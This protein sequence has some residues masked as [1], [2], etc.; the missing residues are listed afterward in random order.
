MAAKVLS[1]RSAYF[2]GGSD[3]IGR[4]NLPDGNIG[5]VGITS[6]TE[7][8]VIYLSSADVT[9]NDHPYLAYTIQ[10]VGHAVTVEFTCQNVG[11]ATDPDP[12]VQAN[13]AW[14]NSTTVSPGTFATITFGF[15]ALKVTFS[16]GAGTECYIVCR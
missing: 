4:R 7:G 10:A 12:E 2:R 16:G 6:N 8:D 1:N 15:S 9:S 11:M 13:V 5:W 3:G 14:C